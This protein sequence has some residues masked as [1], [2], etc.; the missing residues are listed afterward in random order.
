MYFFACVTQNDCDCLL[1]SKR[2]Q[3]SQPGAG[4]VI[5]R[6]RGYRLALH[7]EGAP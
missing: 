5:V 2:L 7:Q 6:G 1:L 3:A 4:A